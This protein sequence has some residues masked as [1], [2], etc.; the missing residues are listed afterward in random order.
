M[1]SLLQDVRE[2]MAYATGVL[3]FVG[4]VILAVSHGEGAGEAEAVRPVL[5]AAGLKGAAGEEPVGLVRVLRVEAHLVLRREPE[6]LRAHRLHVPYRLRR[7][8]VV[9]HLHKSTRGAVSR[10]GALTTKHRETKYL[11]ERRL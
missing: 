2:L 9:D 3:G 10:S 5:V 8:A 1:W 4:P 6:E 7:D 11:I